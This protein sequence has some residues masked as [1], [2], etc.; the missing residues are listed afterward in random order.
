M[1]EIKKH[2]GA[3]IKIQVNNC[4]DINKLTL[5][6]IWRGKRPPNSQHNIEGDNKVRGLA[7]PDSKTHNKAT[8]IKA[9][10]YWC[11]DRNTDPWDR[12]QKQTYTD[13]IT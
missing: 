4:V 10:W 13:I 11:K 6:F 12:V 8:V 5:K 3:Q 9:M 7:L 1:F 2:M